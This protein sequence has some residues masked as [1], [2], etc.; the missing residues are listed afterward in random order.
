MKGGLRT[1]LLIRLINTIDIPVRMSIDRALA[2]AQNARGMVFSGKRLEFVLERRLQ[3]SNA[4]FC[5]LCRKSRPLLASSVTT[6]VVREVPPLRPAK[7]TS[8]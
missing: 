2:I 1:W 4:L 6:R 3:K 7:Y 8:L 5:A